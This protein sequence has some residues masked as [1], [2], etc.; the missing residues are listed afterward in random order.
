MLHPL[1]PSTP[2]SGSIWNR[3]NLGRFALSPLS[4]TASDSFAFG[5]GVLWG[6]VD[7][8]C[9]G[10]D[11][12]ITHLIRRRFRRQWAGASNFMDLRGVDAQP[13]GKV[14]K[15]VGFIQ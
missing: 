1:T 15:W 11:F 4:F 12:I 2:R 3:K 14:A 10:G 6:Y 9:P 7:P 13:E 8:P 5:W